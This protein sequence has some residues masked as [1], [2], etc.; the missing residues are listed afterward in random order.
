MLGRSLLL[1]LAMLFSVSTVGAAEPERVHRITLEEYEATLGYWNEQHPEVLTVE[2]VGES[3]AGLGIHLL[4]ITDPDVDD[5]LKQIALVTAL[6]G[7]PERSGTTTILHFVE[8]LLGDT[9]DARETR[10]KQIVLLMPINHPEAF[11]QTD[12]FRNSEK[13]DPYTGGGPA[14]WDLERLEYKTPE[15]APE[16][17][18]V[19]NVID[20]WQPDVHADMHGTGLQEYPLEQLGDRTR[21]QGQIMFEVTGSAYSNFALRPWD[22]RVTEEIIRAGEE[23][24]FPSDRFEADAQRSFHGPVMGPIAD[25]TWSGQPN[26]YTAQYGYA[27]Y[28]TMVSAFEIAWEQSGVARLKGL[29]KI[30]NGRWQNEPHEGYPVDRVASYTGHFVTAYGET[31]GA[32][33][34]SRFEL[35]QKQ[36]QFT[37]A[38]LY[39]QTDGRDTYL[40]A[41]STA[42]AD[43]LQKD[44]DQFLAGISQREDVD[45]TAVQKFVRSGP[46][47][48]LAV[49]T[50]RHPVTDPEP[51]E[52]GIGFRLRLPYRQPTIDSVRLNG[53]PLPQSSTHGWQSWRANGYTQVQV[54]LPPEVAARHELFMITCEYTPDVARPIGWKP[55]QAVLDRLKN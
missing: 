3:A 34:R 33:R 14:N 31:A 46:E 13:I 32:R 23:A 41:T 20:R 22:W 15:K 11:F 4:K 6:H 5:D 51:I 55:P 47:V 8:W 38:I 52:H 36:G 30:G 9:E 28:H 2:R 45:S 21:Y 27:K 43:V 53:H 42:A 29:L 7:G 39:P 25:R 48:L 17:M 37:Q 44:L 50:A 54:N 16:V 10:R 26:F 12:R 49:S 24:G 40:V 35:W 18:A 19:L 1:I